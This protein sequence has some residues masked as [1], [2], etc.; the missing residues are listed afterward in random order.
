MHL[1]SCPVHIVGDNVRGEKMSY[2]L[3]VEDNP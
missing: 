2:A 1:L 3:K